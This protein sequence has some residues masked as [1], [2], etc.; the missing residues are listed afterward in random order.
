MD[1]HC[2]L[3]PTDEY[4]SGRTA[5]TFIFI[6]LLVLLSLLRGSLAS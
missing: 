2:G 6:F 5:R 4:C 3:D 1:V